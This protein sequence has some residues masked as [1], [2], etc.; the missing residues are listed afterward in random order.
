VTERVDIVVAMPVREG[1]RAVLQESL[2]QRSVAALA[3]DAVLL[4]LHHKDAA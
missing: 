4:P 1:R 2:R 3:V